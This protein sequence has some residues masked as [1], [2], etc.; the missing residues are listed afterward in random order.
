MDKASA[1]ND[2]SMITL[3][4]E[5]QH[6]YLTWREEKV[7]PPPPKPKSFPFLFFFF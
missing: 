6:K 1:E 7:G 2:A 5:S 3:N 4:Y